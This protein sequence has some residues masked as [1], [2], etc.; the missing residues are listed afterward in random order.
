MVEV[1]VNKFVQEYSVATV[2]AVVVNV[3]MNKMPNYVRRIGEERERRILERDEEREKRMMGYVADIV[4]GV[5]KSEMEKYK[6][7][8]K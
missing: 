7:E 4:H 6:S 5:V 1:D 3:L 8:G 2:A